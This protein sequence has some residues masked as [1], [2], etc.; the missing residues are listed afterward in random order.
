MSLFILTVG[1]RENDDTN[2]AIEVTGLKVNK[3]GQK[4]TSNRHH[5]SNG[6]RLNLEVSM[7][8][9]NSPI[10]KI[11]DSWNCNYND[12]GTNEGNV[13]RRGLSVEPKTGVKETG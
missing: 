3:P 13:G 11:C 7:K 8:V 12:K 9:S 2:Y 6:Q 10:D 5:K 4:D 1:T